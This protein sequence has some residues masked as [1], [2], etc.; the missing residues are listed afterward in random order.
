MEVRKGY[1]QTEVGMIPEDW[2]VF[3][4]RSIITYTKGY[5]FKSKEYSETGIRIIRVSDTNADSIKEDGKIYI[6][7]KFTNL[8]KQ[9]VLEEYDLI[10][11]TVGSKPPMYDSIVGKPILVNRK[12]HGSLLNQNAVSLRSKSRNVNNQFIIYFNLKQKRYL[13]HIEEIFRGNANQASITLEDLFK[14]KIPLPSAFAEQEAIATVLSDTDTLISSLE[15]LLSKKRQIK[16]GTMQELL[17]GKRRLPGFTGEWETKRL[18]EIGIVNKGKGIKK[19]EIQSDGLPCIRYGEIYTH[20]N[21]VV[22]EFNSYITEI[23]AKESYRLSYGDILFAGSGETSEEIGKCVA[24]TKYEMAYAGGDII[25]LSPINQDSNFLGYYL[26]HSSIVRQKSIMGQG[27]AIVHIYPNAI[28]MIQL[29]LPSKAE[30]AAIASVLSDM[31]SEIEVLEKKISK[32]KEI[33]QGM[34]QKLLTGEIRLV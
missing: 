9:W 17:T 32:Y 8:Y 16:L 28:K 22:K 19:T 3:P 7:P 13:N 23:T 26:N 11:T 30:Q 18:E 4:I 20:H 12:N 34:M 2:E 25:I 24:F 5:P 1:K 14:F 21:E 6:D 29:H 10:V 33:K 31:D 15:T 27:D